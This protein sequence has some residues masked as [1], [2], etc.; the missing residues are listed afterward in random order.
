MK[1]LL[2]LA[3]G[4]LLVAIASIAFG[5]SH[6]DSG[7]GSANA[8]TSAPPATAAAPTPAV[9]QN[10]EDSMPRINIEETKK[11]LADGKAV[12]IDV[13]GTDSYKIEH[14]KGAIDYPLAKLEEG[15]FKGLPRD[16]RIIAYCA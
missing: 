13:R 5:C 3:A 9:P 14:I 7:V 10:P 11:L 6:G 1:T 4:A 8:P 16:K 12:I 15:D 2:H